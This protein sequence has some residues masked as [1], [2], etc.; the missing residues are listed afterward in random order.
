MRGQT[1]RRGIGLALEPQRAADHTAGRRG[2]LARVERPA[3]RFVVEP[4]TFLPQLDARA[5]DGARHERDPRSRI[6]GQQRLRER[7]ARP[8]AGV[9]G[10]LKS[11]GVPHEVQRVTR[12]IPAIVL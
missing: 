11:P 7:H 9:V 1:C 4:G 3:Q 2:G 5:S 6:A 8:D 10:A 12:H